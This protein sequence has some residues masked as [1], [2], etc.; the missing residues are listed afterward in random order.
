MSAAPVKNFRVTIFD[1][2]RAAY[3]DDYERSVTAE[4]ANEELTLATVDRLRSW[5]ERNEAAVE[6]ADLELLGQYL[7]RLLFAGEIGEEF[8]KSYRVFT[9]DR[10]VTK[11]LRLR[12]W[13]LFHE[14]ASG[15]ASYP[16]EFIYMP[17]EGGAGYFFAAREELALTRFVPE[18]EAFKEMEPTKRPLRLLVAYCH[19]KPLDE[20]E[21][22]HILETFKTLEQQDGIEVGEILENCTVKELKDA[23]KDR[24]PHVLHFIG[25]G[26]Q[27]RIA[28]VKS[29]EEMA[30]DFELH[31]DNSEAK[32]CDTETV[33][34][35]F[36]DHR[37][38]LVFLHACKT[39][40]GYSESLRAFTSTARELVYSEIPAVIGMQF[41]IESQDA[42]NFADVFYREIAAGED[43]DTAVA[44]GRR[45]LGEDPRRGA[46][47][48][49][50]FGTPLVYLQTYKPVVLS[51]PPSLDEGDQ[52]PTMVPC[53][54]GCRTWV[55]PDYK[56]C[57]TCTK[58][59]TTCR[60][61]HPVAARPGRCPIC[62]ADVGG[63][64]LAAT[65]EASAL[66]GA[67]PATGGGGS[68]VG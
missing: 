60:S 61:G 14:E 48:D 41:E 56:E 2:K 5:V 28:L 26:D 21:V 19:P 16:W 23:I 25:H 66:V 58:P 39:A 47:A 40:A 18:L 45:R 63:P 65:G 11:N 59:L 35:F 68:S 44:A 49:R 6:R 9:K 30:E 67:T 32:W 42:A 20:I 52:R 31:G 22:S 29:P 55:T 24:E 10:E 51:P 4:L 64:V 8:E 46:W 33:R 50:R 62:Q 3:K 43:I 36:A 54:W 13:L 15:L 34:T 17:R 7:Y 37:P 27:G 57:P 53:P 12:L 38:R 1:D